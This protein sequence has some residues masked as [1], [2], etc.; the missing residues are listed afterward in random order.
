MPIG[1]IPPPTV[2]IDHEPTFCLQV[3]REWLPALLAIVNP[4]RYPEFWAGTLEEN[5][6]ARLQAKQLLVKL[7]EM[8][9]CGMAT[10]CEPPIYLYRQNTDTGRLERSV[11]MG[12]T[13]TPDPADPIFKTTQ[14]PAPVRVGFSTTK[15]DASTNFTTHFQ[16]A[17]TGC[18]ENLGTA[19]T[20]VELAGGIAALVLDLFII[21]VFEAAAPP[22]IAT[23]TAAIFAGIS[24][25]FTEGKA[26]FDAYWDS[27]VI[28]KI[29]CAAYCTI[30]EDGTWDQ[31]GWE[32]FKHK[33]RS[34]A[35]PGAALDMVMTTVNAAGYVGANNMAS[36]GAAAE[37]DCASCEPCVCTDQIDDVW[38]FFNVTDVV[39]DGCHT[40]T[41]K[42]VGGGAHFA[43]TTGDCDTGYYWDRPLLW[44]TASTWE[45]AVAC[46][47]NNDVDPKTHPI[48]NFD[49]G[50][51]ALD[52]VITIVFSNSPI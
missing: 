13:W 34:T 39:F 41:M 1:T 24:A 17:I 4:A 50:P 43:A 26:A 49:V 45:V 46:G 5:R 30:R 11:D 38:E 14:Q 20:L 51:I 48:W 6:F 18:S 23:I 15:C 10:C 35:P 19:V 44:S 29:L 25:A 21:V 32:D 2:S 22:I 8:E 37:S 7:Q 47:S 9:D 52:E 33:V 16:D 40:Y 31:T 36:Y 3:S 27:D 12:T 28:D 42:G